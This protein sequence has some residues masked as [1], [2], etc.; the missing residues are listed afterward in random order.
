[1]YVCLADF[2]SET[3]LLHPILNGDHTSPS[4]V[5]CHAV[6]LRM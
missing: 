5:V 2:N 1:M 3:V 6:L 4:S